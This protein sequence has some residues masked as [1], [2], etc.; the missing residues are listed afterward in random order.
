MDYFPRAGLNTSAIY[1]QTDLVQDRDWDV[2]QHTCPGPGQQHGDTWL[3]RTEASKLASAAVA[4]VSAVSSLRACG[5]RCEDT[6]GCEVNTGNIS[7][8]DKIRVRAVN[9]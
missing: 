6:A 5:R 9:D 2:W 4:A 3:L 7:Y 1:P 8:E